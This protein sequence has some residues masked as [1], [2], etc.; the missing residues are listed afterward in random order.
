MIEQRGAGEHLP[1]PGFAR[2]GESFWGFETHGVVPDV[3]VL[4][5]P[6]GNG[7]PLAAVITTRDIAATQAELQTRGVPI[8][9]EARREPWGLREMHVADPDGNIIPLGSAIE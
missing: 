9:R 1:N 8:A 4:G 3:V 6:I 2:L 5:K 7:F